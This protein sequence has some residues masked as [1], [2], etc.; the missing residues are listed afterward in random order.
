MAA[1]RRPGHG[2]VRPVP[3]RPTDARRRSASSTA[4]S[5]P[6][7]WSACRWPAAGPR[8]PDRAAGSCRSASWPSPG[9]HNVG[10]ALA[11]VAVGLLFG[12][13]P[14]AIRDGRRR[15]SPAS[16]TASRRSRSSMA[17]ASSTTRRAR[18]PTR[19]SPRCARSTAPIVLI[20]GGRDKGVD[21]SRPAAGRRR[22][23]RRRG[24]HR[25]ER[26]GPRPPL[27]RPPASP[28]RRGA[29]TTS[30]PRSRAPTPSPAPRWPTP[31]RGRAGDRA[32]QPGRRQLRHVRGL[33]RPRAGLQGRRALAAGVAPTR[34]RGGPDEPRTAAPALRSPA[35]GRSGE[36][37]AAEQ[38]RADRRDAPIGRRR[39]RR[40]RS[41]SA[42]ATS[43]TT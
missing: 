1:L 18:S 42:S 39:S 29:R 10:N 3:A 21:L 41:S 26:P 38:A 14:D 27:P 13:A 19:S 5:W 30:R 11:A 34:P 24:R 40:P 25:R 8:R 17:S 23:G 4:G 32:A 22:A 28:H 7:A 31:A 35:A 33:R 9:A 16:S 2:A 6:P 15:R 36:L 43:P 12:V 37:D 20:A